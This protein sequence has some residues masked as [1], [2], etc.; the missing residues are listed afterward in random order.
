MKRIDVACG[1]VLNESGEFLITQR[2]GGE[3]SGKWEFPGGKLMSNETP[4]DAIKR[5]LFEELNISV[6]PIT[7]LFKSTF[8]TYNLIFIECIILSTDIILKEHK[9]FMWV[10]KTELFEFDFLDGDKEFIN[11]I[12]FKN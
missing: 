10:N 11:H 5:E 8:E 9:K 4:F 1:V 7:E 3:F 12:C 6:R 2:Q